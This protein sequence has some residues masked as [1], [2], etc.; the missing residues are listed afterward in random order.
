MDTNNEQLSLSKLSDRMK[1]YEFQSTWTQF[2]N[3]WMVL[4]LVDSRVVTRRKVR[5][6]KD[7]L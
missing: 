5:F 4:H 2:K 7:L 3:D 6:M 1:N